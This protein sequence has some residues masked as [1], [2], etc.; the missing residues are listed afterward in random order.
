M[1]KKVNLNSAGIN[2]LMGKGLMS[3]EEM[4]AMQ[5]FSKKSTQANKENKEADAKRATEAKILSEKKA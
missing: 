4:K 5:A 1:E 3:A 2:A